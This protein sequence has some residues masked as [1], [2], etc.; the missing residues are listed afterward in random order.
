MFRE[1]I[2]KKHYSFFDEASSWEDAIRKACSS[3]IADNTV[4]SNYPEDIIEC[5]KKYG[6]YIVIAPLVAIP[7]CQEN[8]KGVNNTAVGFMKL[9]KPIAFDENDRELDAQLFFTLASQNPEKH[10]ENLTALTEILCNEDLLEEL[11]KINNIDELNSLVNK[12][13]L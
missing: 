12:Y 4:E 6:P 3:L 1:I 9:N 10:L 5:I 13:N 2:E 7:H 11:K 8:A